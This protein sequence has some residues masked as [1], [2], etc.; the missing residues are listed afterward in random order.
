MSVTKSRYDITSA[1]TKIIGFDYQFFY[2]MKAVLSLKREQSAGY[3]AKDDVHITLPDGRL[4]L[5]QLKHTT[6]QTS[7][8]T[9]INLTELDGDLIKSLYN[10]V[11]IICDARDGRSE[12]SSQISFVKNTEFILATNKGIENNDFI[13]NI[14]KVQN[15]TMKSGDLKIYIKGLAEE[16]ES[17]QIQIYLNTLIK[18][19]TKVFNEFIK[20][21]KFENQASE[22]SKEIKQLIA[23]D[24][25]GESRINDVFNSLFSELKLAH[26]EAV[27]QGKKL[28]VEY[29]TWHKKIT[30]IFENNRKTTLPIRKINIL[31]PD[32]LEEQ[33]F[34]KELIAIGDVDILQ[35]GQ[36]E[37]F[38]S[39]M[40]EVDFNLKNWFDYGDITN[41]ELDSFKEE[42][43]L[44]WKNTHRSSH[45]TT[46][47]NDL[48]IT[49]ALTCLDQIRTK[50]LTIQETP[51]KLEFSNGNFYRLANEN[52]L[53]WLKKWEV[54][55]K[56]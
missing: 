29:D 45:R 5:V 24:Y 30:T 11:L 9:P 42:A 12:Q 10:W 37:E 32:K 22:I 43:V 31:L 14:I 23:D 19:N 6:Q 26:M 21:L 56:K 7:S 13:N 35:I 28:I 3:E 47:D 41:K 2:F 36:I 18:L 55:Y 44:F 17:V 8:G 20:K 39:F 33:P 1:D 53:G 52:E 25:I 50:E 40:L 48:D 15:V 34:I 46:Y 54:K 16:T 27:Q 4:I 38:T 49:N 51:L